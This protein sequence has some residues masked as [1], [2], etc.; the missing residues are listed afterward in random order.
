MP[1]FLSGFLTTALT[2]IFETFS[3]RAYAIAVSSSLIAAIISACYLISSYIVSVVVPDPVL[4]VFDVIAPVDWPQQLSLIV[5]V[6]SISFSFSQSKII[7]D[8][9]LSGG[10]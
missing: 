6:K 2:W 4:F 5:F 8:S 9:L 3:N 1:V 10:G 7:H